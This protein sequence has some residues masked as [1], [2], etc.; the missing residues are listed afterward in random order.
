MNKINK[1]DIKLNIKNHEYQLVNQPEYIFTSVTTFEGSF[2]E[3][4]DEVKVANH[5]VKNVLLW[6]LHHQSLVLKVS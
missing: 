3:P 6:Q 4:F 1:K 2:F 5:L